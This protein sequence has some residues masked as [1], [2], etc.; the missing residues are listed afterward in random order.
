MRRK[1]ILSGLT[2]VAVA[3]LAASALPADARP[4]AAVPL[5]GVSG[6]APVLLRG[7]TDLG[8]APQR[9]EHA[10]VAL[11]LRDR[12]GLDALLATPGH[13]DLTPAAFVDRFAPTQATVDAATAWA[14]DAGLTVASVSSNRTLVSVTAPTAV[15]DRALG[16]STHLFR[17]G[18]TT[19]RSVSSTAA[20]PASLAG[21]VVGITGLSD[22]G[23]VRLA[24]RRAAPAAHAA[25]AATFPR[26]F[27]PKELASFYDA[28][29]SATGSGQTVGVIAEGDLTQVKKDLAQ[30]ESTYGLPTVPVSV[31]GP[32]SSD[33]TGQG[34]F[35]LDT[36][37]ATG[38]APGVAGLRI[39]DGVSL[40]NT[41]IL[42]IINLWATE[43]TVK[44]ASFSAG[45]CEL[46]AGVTGFTTSLDQVLAQAAAQ[47]Q[48]LFVSSG[49]NG[50]FCTAF[51]GIN[52]IPAGIP[53]VEYPASSPYAVGVG[54]TTVTAG[55]LPAPGAYTGE[56]TWYGGGGG[57]SYFETKPDYQTSPVPVLRG[58][59][60]VALDADPLTGYE[61]IVSGQKQVIGGT[62]A[63]A[64][65]W[66]GYWARALGAR[67]ALG[68]AGPRL[69]GA[70][71][72]FHD[73]V[74]GSNGLYPATP[75]YDYTTGLGT[76]DV[77]ALIP[78]L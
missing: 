39:Y 49:D 41:D 52:G 47:G 18:A 21:Q 17:A 27:G 25:P 20:L 48:S 68:F 33:V 28:P 77:A 5:T 36:Q 42:S 38:E 8:A 69:Y 34:E 64:P 2:A 59:P 51:V 37:Y 76:P 24:A 56:V 14:R 12:A 32:G 23:A 74:V 43:G 58:V 10:A 4:T 70:K 11:R 45:E 67:G 19:Y 50:S 53:G 16:T 57:L 72:G 1:T 63:S 71:A 7:A 26:S 31:A 78:A 44:T 46:L 35:D 62:S 6:A 73:I 60:D 61:V 15:L 66:N 22:L 54:G 3:S 9:T 40:A 65:A 75:G 29:A 30:F 55:L 13:A